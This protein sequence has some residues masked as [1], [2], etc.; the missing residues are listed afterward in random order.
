MQ[1]L[2][3]RRGDT[4][5]AK[6]QLVDNL[7]QAL[8]ITGMTVQASLIDKGGNVARE[9]T[10]TVLNENEGSYA[11][12]PFETSTIP[13]ALY[14]LQVVYRKSGIKISNTAFELRISKLIVK[15]PVR[16]AQVGSVFGNTRV[17]ITLPATSADVSLW[18]VDWDVA[19][20]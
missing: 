7:G 9:L 15:E 14:V 10:T 19:W 20:A 16:F 6:C 2:S 13:P 12:D 8:P 17:L 5:Y 18:D 3:I 11:L 1:Q 4:F